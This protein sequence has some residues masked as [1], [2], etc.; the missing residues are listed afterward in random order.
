MSRD[1]AFV[2]M[3]SS[4]LSEEESL[5]SEEDRLRRI[6]Q[7]RLAKLRSGPNDETIDRSKQRETRD[8]A[9]VPRFRLHVATA[10]RGPEITKDQGPS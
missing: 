5:L 1:R 4:H 3:K 2:S 10:M 8:L 6:I 9:T 7:K